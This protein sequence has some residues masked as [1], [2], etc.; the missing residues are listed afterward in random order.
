MSNNPYSADQNPN[1]SLAG[2]PDVA[3]GSSIT[4]MPTSMPP[5][6]RI[7][8]SIKPGSEIHHMGIVDNVNYYDLNLAGKDP[9]PNPPYDEPDGLHINE[10]TFGEQ[11]Y[12]V[13]PNKAFDLQAPGVD[14]HPAMQVDPLVG[15]LLQ[16]DRPHGLDIMAAS[17][18]PLAIDPMNPDFSEYDR[19]DNLAM[20][21]PL[22][23]DPALPDLQD[24]TTTQE[25]N[26]M[27]DDRPAELSDEALT[28]MHS[29]ATY[30]AIPSDS[31]EE[32]YMTQTG[33]NQTRERHQGMLMLGLDREEG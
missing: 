1:L 21:G 29:N 33:N 3:S 10:P 30:K 27:L 2:T 16:F 28:I 14:V 26:S 31:Y 5:I 7:Q 19:P 23:V 15:D 32:L 8:P 18:N 25:V 13:P 9:L 4:N 22:M 17:A 20:P 12:V 11:N 24:P 6:P